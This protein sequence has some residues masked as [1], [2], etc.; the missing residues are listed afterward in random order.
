MSA[1][2]KIPPSNLEAEMA[3]I[4]SVLL[5]R[6]MLPV[7]LAHVK[8][9][10]FY[11]H[12]HEVIWTHILAL[13]EADAPIDKITLAERLRSAGML[14]KAGGVPYLNS[15]LDIVPT[16]S[17]VEY[18]ASIVADKA[19]SRAI[20]RVARELYEKA[21]N[22]HFE[23][24]AELQDYA[25]REITSALA[26][27]AITVTSLDE[28]VNSVVARIGSPSV[29]PYLS[30]WET[31]DR[32]TGGFKPGELIVWGAAPGMGKCQAANTKVTDAE[33][34]E[35][36]TIR[37]FVKEQRK[38]TLS[39]SHSGKIEPRQVASWIPSGIQ[40]CYALR[41]RSGR[42]NCATEAHPFLTTEGWAPLRAL[43]RGDR[44]AV[45]A[46]AVHGSEA[47]DPQLARLLGYYFG[48]GSMA[49]ISGPHREARGCKACGSHAGFTN[50]DAEIV[51]DF[52]QIIADKFP[53][54]SVRFDGKFGYFPAER[55]GRGGRWQ[56][57]NLVVSWLR[58]FGLAG[59]L[60][61][62]KWIPAEV[63]KWDAVALREFLR[64]LM[65]CD[66]TIYCSKGMA[67]IIEITLAS[68]RLVRDLQHAFLRFGIL[69]DFSTKGSKA[70][71]L[72]IT[73]PLSIQAYQSSIGWIGEKTRR[74]STWRAS[75]N[76]NTNFRV[77]GRK[78][79]DTIRRRCAQRGIS[80]D[81]L[82]RR[83]AFASKS[84]PDRDITQDHLATIATVLKDRWLAAL[85][86]PDIIW[87][88]IKEI[89]SVGPMETFDLEVPGHH[90][91]V[92][93][94]IVVHNSIMLGNYA[95]YTAHAYNPKAFALFSLEMTQ[96]DS[97]ER[98]LSMRAGV[99][100]NKI[101]E[102][103][104]LTSEDWR[105]L[106]Y[107]QRALKGIP[108][109]FVTRHP[110]RSLADV[111]RASRAIAQKHGGLSGIAI[112]HIGFV[113]DLATASEKSG[114]KHN[115]LDRL[116]AELLSLADEL[117]CPVHVVYHLNRGAKAARPTMFDLR[118][119]GNTEGHATTIIFPWRPNPG[120]DPEVVDDA[121]NPIPPT[122]A[123]AA[124]AKC[125]HG[126]PGTVAMY[127]DGVESLWLEATDQKPWFEKGY[128]VG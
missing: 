17:S 128:D 10:D 22:E 68:E 51:A 121:G 57:E 23:S 125:R 9:A 114:G 46:K 15:L 99:P 41:T 6:E 110:R 50:A 39:L 47:A 83:A 58:G 95:E 87:D 113:S 32:L 123:E 25:I 71:R 81:E 37:D 67:P 115:A 97:A 42:E 88:E 66:G 101:R 127:F 11:A 103:I 80:L 111:K 75:P 59:H 73:S 92:A 48:D 105:A 76:S 20:I 49:S 1:A 117:S 93:D 33:T 16:A 52:S 84:H 85:A 72:V 3:V 78:V 26:S 38:K 56:S 116:L 77:V 62:E 44:I 112:D 34:G 65:S 91:F 96:E 28:V 43:R 107:A 30:Q 5:E 29:R 27:N 13:Y 35:R 60:S 102:G 53:S 120:N 18:Y 7:A 36:L 45:S 63:W 104:R 126:V 69:A 108:I 2:D 55:G 106:E 74:F 86:S 31:L 40:E 61:K 54:L 19:G 118:D 21:Y 82:D 4:G 119:G 14:E 8:A 98:I 12:I 70:W 64:A 124:V 24:S 122:R 94:D 109:E 90:N 89:K 100:V 79:W